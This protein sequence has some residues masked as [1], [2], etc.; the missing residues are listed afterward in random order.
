MNHFQSSED[1]TCGQHLPKKCM[2]YWS[3]ANDVKHVWF[4]WL[5]HLSA[6]TSNKTIMGVILPSHV[7]LLVWSVISWYRSLG[8]FRSTRWFISAAVAF[9]WTKKKKKWTKHKSY[10]KSLLH[11]CQ[12]AKHAK[13]QWW[14]SCWLKNRKTS[15][16]LPDKIDSFGE[17][18]QNRVG[19]SGRTGP[20]LWISFSRFCSWVHGTCQGFYSY[21]ERIHLNWKMDVRKT[22]LIGIQKDRQPLNAALKLIQLQFHRVNETA[23]ASPIHSIC[24]SLRCGR[25]CTEAA[26]NRYL[27]SIVKAALLHKPVLFHH[28]SACWEK[29]MW[30]SKQKLVFHFWRAWSV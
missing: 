13:G 26:G 20:E 18:L 17:Q 4:T 10:I 8:C 19:G 30:L 28:S 2:S 29:G 22:C 25:T 7:T 15:S 1:K 11:S 3:L 9:I 23:Y 24:G 5:T 6:L 16:K 27:F 12:E 21:K 14:G